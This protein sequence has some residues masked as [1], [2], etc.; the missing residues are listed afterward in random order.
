PEEFVELD[1][2][3]Q[4]LAELDELETLE[5]SPVIKSELVNIDST[6]FPL[7]THLI[8]LALLQQTLDA[9]DIEPKVILTD[10]NLAMEKIYENQVFD[11]YNHKNIDNI[12]DINNQ[13]SAN[14]IN[15]SNNQESANNIN[16]DNNQE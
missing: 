14:N 12:K 2:S 16:D 13:A 7:L 8:E 15:V 3:V 6:K 9:T 11:N 1:T 5:E 4:G 10:I